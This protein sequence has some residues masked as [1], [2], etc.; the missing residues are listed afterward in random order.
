MSTYR[1]QITREL[2]ALTRS[3]VLARDGS[4]LVVRD[5]D[6]LQRIVQ[7]TS[8]PAPSARNGA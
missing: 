7:G 5:M 8:V 6:R 3:G 1:E 2:S 4:A